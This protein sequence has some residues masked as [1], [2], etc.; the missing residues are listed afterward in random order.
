[1]G[2]ERALGGDALEKFRILRRKNQ[3]D[4]M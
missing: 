3:V 1:L 4:C 2:Q